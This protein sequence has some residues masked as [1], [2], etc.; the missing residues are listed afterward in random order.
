MNLSVHSPCTFADI[1]ETVE[2]ATHSELGM[3]RA[4]IGAGNSFTLRD[5]LGVAVVCGGYVRVPDLPP[6]WGQAWFL[7]H[8]ER[9]GPIMFDVISGI[10]LTMR[11]QP[12]AGLTVELGT[13]AGR[14]LAKRLGFKP[15]D[16]NSDYWVWQ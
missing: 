5:G 10:A 4:Q 1:A 9:A 12:Y 16:G 14:I 7:V 13:R 15:Q 6:N 11:Q 8:A 2:R 3:L